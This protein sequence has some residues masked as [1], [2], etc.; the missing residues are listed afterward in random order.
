MTSAIRPIEKVP[1]DKRIRPAETVGKTI[2]SKTTIEEKRVRPGETKTTI[3]SKT[4]E[5]KRVRPADS[6]DTRTT[7]R[8]TR[9]VNKTEVNKKTVNTTVVNK[10]VVNT[11]VVNRT[12]I[13]E[14]RVN[15]RFVED[16]YYA[17][18]V[19]DS[20]CYVR[21]HDSWSFG[22]SFGGGGDSF[23][24]GY[25]SGCSPVYVERYRLFRSLSSGVARSWLSAADPVS[26]S[27]AAAARVSSSPSRSW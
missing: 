20:R 17:E 6:R 3:D 27:P 19:W 7:E 13:N 4:V 10:K 18:P 9:V 21:P 1:D 22:M 11:T 16:R 2:D 15:R 8:D 14:T 24:F 12:V 23:F 25:S 26:L 5:E